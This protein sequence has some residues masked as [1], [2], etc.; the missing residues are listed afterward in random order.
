[1]MII[2]RYL[3]N[4]DCY[5]SAT[6]MNIRG[7]MIHSVGCNVENPLNFIN[8]WDKPDFFK[9]VHAF[10][11]QDAI[12]ETLPYNYRAWH[13]GRGING[14][15]NDGY[16]SVELTEPKSISYI[17]GGSFNDENPDYTRRFV[18]NSYRNAVWYFA[19][20][21]RKFNLNPLQK[22]VVV[23]H[24]EAYKLGYASNHG[25]VEHIWSY[26]GLSM[27]KFRQDIKDEIKNISDSEKEGENSK[28][29][30]V[31]PKKYCIEIE[32]K[33]VLINGK[34][35]DIDMI[36]IKNYNYAKLDDLKKY[37][38]DINYNRKNKEISINF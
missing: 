9:C 23:S 16:I 22:N 8:S 32:K 12:Y 19:Y 35:S 20:L 15:F 14:S 34:K 17:K 7:L 18:Y 21:C 26:L 13:C 1:M 6:I 27:D 37:G 29:S 5:K 36:N 25:D 38:L 10:I 11:G 28:N 30:P 24:S 3:K 33:Q 31:Y 2:N 4:N